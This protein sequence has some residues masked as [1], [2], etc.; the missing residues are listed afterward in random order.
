MSST[1]TSNL[2]GGV[3]KVLANNPTISLRSKH[4]RELFSAVLESLK[5]AVMGMPPC[6]RMGPQECSP[7]TGTRS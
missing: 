7:H 6:S 3:S 5:E 4:P 2:V 1:Q